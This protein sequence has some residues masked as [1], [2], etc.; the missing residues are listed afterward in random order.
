VQAD[1][2]A[3]GHAAIGDEFAKKGENGFSELLR[4]GFYGSQEIMDADASHWNKITQNDLKQKG[5]QEL[6]GVELVE[7]QGEPL[8]DLA[9]NRLVVDVCVDSSRVDVVWPDGTS[10]LKEPGRRGVI[11]AEM[12]GQAGS[13]EQESYWSI[14]KATH[15]GEEC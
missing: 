4:L 5:E 6:I 11:R 14:A 13:D 1:G 8:A 9:R 12:Q 3:A 15:T 2:L 7:V 10:A